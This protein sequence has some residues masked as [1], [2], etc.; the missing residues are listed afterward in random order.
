MK[1]NGKWLPK[2]A[3]KITDATLE[4]QVSQDSMKIS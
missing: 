2:G 4:T 3:G 1:L